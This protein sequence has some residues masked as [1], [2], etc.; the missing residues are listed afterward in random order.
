MIIVLSEDDW[1]V[2][3]GTLKLT[4]PIYDEDGNAVVPNEL[5]YTLTDWSGAVMNGL[6]GEAIV[7]ASSVDIVLT[8]DD[9][10][11]GDTT[12]Q[13]FLLIEGTYDSS[14]GNDLEMRHQIEFTINGLVAVS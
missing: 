13:R 8:G 10:V 9:L 3:K 11:I 1:P 12:P 5:S 4:V 2:E 7:P 14:D 6:E